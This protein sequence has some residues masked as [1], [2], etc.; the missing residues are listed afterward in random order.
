MSCGSRTWHLLTWHL[1][2]QHDSLELELELEQR[3]HEQP[4][5]LD[6]EL[7]ELDAVH[8]LLAVDA[9]DALLAF[10][11]LFFGVDG[12]FNFFSRNFFL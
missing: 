3:S 5:E 12:I 2:S 10:K 4:L 11:N 6:D 9:V 8:T 7:V 1:R